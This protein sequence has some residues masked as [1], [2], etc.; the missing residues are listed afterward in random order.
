MSRL[1]FRAD[2]DLAGMVVAELEARGLARKTEDGVSIPLH[3]AVRALVLVL[4]AQILR[5]HGARMGLDLSPVTDQTR[6][7]G[8]LTKLLSLPSA[9]SAGSVVSFDM[10]TVGVDLGPIPIDEVLDFRR[11]HLQEHRAY[12]RKVRQFVRELGATPEEQR[13]EAFE[14]RQEELDDL[15]RDL[16]GISRRAWRRPAAFALTLAGASWTAASGNPTGALFAAG[17]GILGAA[18]GGGADAGAYSYLFR[19]VKSYG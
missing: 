2:A 9:P 3:P 13:P 7:V 12:A 19:A 18:S 16:K 4:L 1:G 5:P 15:A 6:L 10:A 17:A 14:D 11:Q 8:T